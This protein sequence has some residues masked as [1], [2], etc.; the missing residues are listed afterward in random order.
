MRVAYGHTPPGNV[1]TYEQTYFRSVGERGSID[2]GLSSRP[3]D[4]SKQ[5]GFG[6]SPPRGRRGTWQRA[7]TLWRRATVLG[8]TKAT[9]ARAA[10]L[11]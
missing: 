10:V 3:L 2:L 7:A 11:F 1:R 5:T 6:G 8:L 4:V 9:P